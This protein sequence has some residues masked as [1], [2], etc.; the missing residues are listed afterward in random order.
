MAKNTANETVPAAHTLSLDERSSMNLTGVMEVLSFD[1]TQICLKTSCGDMTISGKE[2]HMQSL[3]VQEGNV[4][5]TGQI[6]AISYAKR[7]PRGA[8][9][10][11]DIFR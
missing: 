7:A 6:D 1:E 11:L 10:L 5:L 9:S 4:R 8:K 2:M 3:F